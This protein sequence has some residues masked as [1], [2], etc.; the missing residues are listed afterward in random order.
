MKRVFV[1]RRFVG[2]RV[3]PWYVK[4]R[5]VREHPLLFS[6][7]EGLGYRRIARLGSWEL[8]VRS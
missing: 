2:V 1:A 4:L 3:G 8:G 7:R 6:E 5:D